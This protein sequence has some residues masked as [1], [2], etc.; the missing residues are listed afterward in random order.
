LTR[1]LFNHVEHGLNIPGTRLDAARAAYESEKD[2]ARKR[3]K[4][5]MLAGALFNRATEIFTKLVEIQA[6]GVEITPDNGLLSECGEHFEEAL[7]LGKLV[8]HRSGEEGID[9]LWGEPLKAFSFPI[10]DFYKNRCI[11]ISQAM[12]DIDRICDELIQSFAG[13]DAFRGA[14]VAI[15]ELA[16]AA[17]TKTETLRTDADIF[18]VWSSFA[19]A[20]EG[21]GKLEPALDQELGPAST[22]VLTDGV[23]LLRRGRDLIS[24]ITRARVSMPK[25]TETFLDR[26]R[27]FRLAIEAL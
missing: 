17:K 5:A 18:D 26:C 12:R 24:D 11:K 25:S 15:R 7:V 16:R 1:R 27:E 4:G 20:L 10:E 21:L 6:L 3:V 22:Q 13:V 2:P 14:D 23:A 8:F 19:V 9:E